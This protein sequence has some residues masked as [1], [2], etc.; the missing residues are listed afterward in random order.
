MVPRVAAVISVLDDALF[1]H[2]KCTGQHLHIAGCLPLD[3]A[4]RSG[5]ETGDSD[6]WVQHG[7]DAA[8]LQ[9]IRFV[10]IGRLVAITIYAGGQIAAIPIGVLRLS[11]GYRD[12]FQ[13]GGGDF[14]TV[15]LQLSQPFTAENSAEVAQEGE[16]GRPFAPQAA[17]LDQIA[18]NSNGRSARRLITYFKF[19]THVTP[20]YLCN[21]LILYTL[22][23]YC[24]S[25]FAQTGEN[26][27]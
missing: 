17:Q 3:M 10:D 18:I 7:S 25:I 6:A 22:Q 14:F 15:Q 1:V 5:A 23:R 21:L 4:A 16:Q 2:N 19:F 13:A 20:L 26:N 11:Q 12:H 27:G 9:P 8:A 24:Q